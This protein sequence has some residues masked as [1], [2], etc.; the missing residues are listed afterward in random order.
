MN[1]THATSQYHSNQN[2]HH[3]QNQPQ[4]PTNHSHQCQ[5]HNNST[6][7]NS[8]TNNNNNNNNQSGCDDLDCFFCEQIATHIEHKRSSA[9]LNFDTES[10]TRK[11]SR[12]Y[13]IPFVIAT[14]V[15]QLTKRYSSMYIFK[16]FKPPQASKPNAIRL[17][18]RL[19]HSLWMFLF[20]NT[21][22]PKFF[23]L[24][25]ITI[26]FISF[27][28]FSFSFSCQFKIEVLIQHFFF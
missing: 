2:H 24:L 21:Q 3:H 14:D 22:K 7:T 13:Q 17:P 26:T 28:C 25:N 8:S 23:F 15:N 1:R 6:N 10:P 4:R 16:R 18:W 27:H 5:T 20:F 11:R 19:L 9:Q 12:F